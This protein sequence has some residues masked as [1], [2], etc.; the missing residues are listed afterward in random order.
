M[1]LHEISVKKPVAVTMIVLIFVV[2]GLYSLTMLPMEMTPDMELSM[3]VVATQY[4]NVGSEEIENMVT[5]T[6]EGSLAGISGVDS[7]TS[8]SSEGMSLIMVQFNNGTDMDKAVADMESAINMIEGFLPEDAED[9]MVLKLDTDMMATAQFSIAYEGYDLVQTK[10]FVD[11]TLEA[12]LKSIDG[13]ANISVS[14]AQNR[15]IDVY[16]DPVK[17]TGYNMSVSDIATAIAAQ[18]QNLP[19]GTTEA[20]GKKLS[21]RLLG[22]FEKVSD[23]ESVPLMTATGQVIALRDV[24]EVRDSYSDVT[25]IARLN[26]SEA[27]SITLTKE[28]D[29]NT[30]DVVN[31]L[32]ETLDEMERANPGFTYSMTMEQGTMIEEAVSS[33][34]SNAVSGAFL[35]ILVLL[36]F[37]GSV[38]SS[39]VIGVAMPVSVITTFIGMYFSGMSLNVVSLGGLALGVG[40]L[41]DNAVVVLENIFR[42]RGLGKDASQASVGGAGEVVGAVIASVLTTCIVYV[43]ILFIDNIMAVM[44]KQLAFA[45][46]FSQIASLLVT[47]L[48]VPMLSSKIKHGKTEW[49]WLKVILT[50]FNKALDVLYRVYKKSLR[51]LLSHRKMFICAVL[52]VFVLC[53]VLLGAL[54][55][56]LI[57]STDSGT[58][59]VSITMPAGTK[60][61][62]TDAM[63]EKFENIISQNPNV[64]SVFAVVGSAGGA[65][66]MLGGGGETD[67]A[68]ITVTL[69]DAA[70]RKD[71]DADVEEQLRQS[72]ADISGA[73]FEVSTQSMA[74]ASASSDE[75]SIQF[76]GSDDEVLE[77]YVKEAEAVL[78][79]VDGVTDT[80]TSIADTR[81]ELHIK[82][83]RTKSMRYALTSAQTA[84]IINGIIAGTTA[85]RFSEGGSEFDIVVK[86]PEQYADTVEK[87]KTLRIKTPGGVWVSVQDIADVEV[88]EGYTTLTRV[89][90]RRVITL[91]ATLYG[92]DLATATTDFNKALQSIPTPD[93]VMQESAG[94][95][96]IM[97]DAMSQLLL[98]IMLGILLMYMVMAA[99][100]G[101]LTDPLIILATI[102]L[103]MIGV[104][105]SLVISQSKLSAVACIGIL[106]LTG[107]IVNNAIVLIEFIAQS[108]EENPGFTTEEHAINAGVT[109]MR[110]VLMTSLTSILGFLPMAMAGDGGAAMMQPLAIV[111]LGGLFVGTFLTLYVIPVVYTSVDKRRDKRKAKKSLKAA[112][113]S[114]AV[115][116]EAP[117]KAEGEESGI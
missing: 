6:V 44:F 2:I 95:Y 90:Q 30:V 64:E 112:A 36:L 62:Q 35:A 107:I 99:Q 101:N 16:I 17:L 84:N 114:G 116:P 28:S 72:L 83:N 61:E 78:A 37:L 75:L 1:K 106:M 8:Q 12:K 48:L 87:V 39:L 56:E 98:A 22:K 21:A 93:G 74:M 102:P 68:S 50:P 34:A 110:P 63:T 59:T 29:A 40:M 43:P 20:F 73:E 60:L 31:D 113:K 57:P 54:G 76:S 25:S 58:V 91:N 18:N 47:F 104:V 65:A 3:A 109:R 105:L 41:V 115:I 24:A 46:I 4:P 26:G 53:M 52:A 85:S 80:G 97:M 103:A 69:K 51:F 86:Y 79:E 66:S 13:V 111:L 38:R 23:I 32:F 15:Q 89:D 10:Q 82:P 27:I 96:E 108:K 14:G 7:I 70:L 5:K 55:M 94:T 11:D 81:Y 45:I 33:V 117:Y 9:P 88:E 19:A 77:R 71:S 92:T 42:H 67:A 49:K 100:F